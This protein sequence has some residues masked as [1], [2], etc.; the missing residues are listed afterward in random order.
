MEVANYIEKI[1][2]EFGRLGFEKEID[3]FRE[4][5]EYFWNQRGQLNNVID[6]KLPDDKLKI[7]FQTHMQKV[8]KTELLEF[9]PMK[10]V[11][12]GKFSVYAWA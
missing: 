6:R 1:Q 9:A 4:N 12:T 2:K 10:I 7:I 5:E 8:E 11:N 3:F